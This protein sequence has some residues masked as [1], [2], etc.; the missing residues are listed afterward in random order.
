MIKSQKGINVMHKVYGITPTA[1]GIRGLMPL[2]PEGHY[3]VHKVYGIT[4][5][6]YGIRRL[7]SWKWLQI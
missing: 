2:M 1:Y 3:V 5:T 6:A 7:L 4:P